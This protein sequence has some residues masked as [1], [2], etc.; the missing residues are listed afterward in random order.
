[1]FDDCL[2]IVI[3]AAVLLL[4]IVNQSRNTDFPIKAIWREQKHINLVDFSVP[5]AVHTHWHTQSQ[6]HEAGVT[7]SDFGQLELFSKTA[8]AGMEAGGKGRQPIVMWSHRHLP[9]QP[10]GR[11][12]TLTSLYRASFSPARSGK[13]LIAVS[14]SSKIHMQRVPLNGAAP[15]EVLLWQ[16][17]RAALRA[18][19]PEY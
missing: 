13:T 2:P 3:G 16:R 17:R 8:A 11:P 7:L 15:F 19:P 10:P 5:V 1:M 14:E 4:A 6:A 12:L 18:E 9:R